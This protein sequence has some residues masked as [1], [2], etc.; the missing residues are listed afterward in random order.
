LIDGS[1]SI[2]PALTFIVDEKVSPQVQELL[3]S[4][5]NRGAVMLVDE[6]SS[7]AIVGEMLNAKLRLSFLL[8]A[9]YG[10][11]LRK[12]KS[13]RLS[14]LLPSKPKPVNHVRS[15]SKQLSLDVD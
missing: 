2:D 7:K 5:V 14:N 9:K 1:F 6:S 12:G 10:L 8:G 15:E 4:A 3:A 13:T 11:L